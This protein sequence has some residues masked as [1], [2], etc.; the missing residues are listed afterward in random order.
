MITDKFLKKTIDEL[1]TAKVSGCITTRSL[2]GNVLLAKV[3]PEPITPDKL[4]QAI[5]MYLIKNEAQYIGCVT[6][7]DI[8]FA[9]MLPAYRRKGLMSEAMRAIILPH[10]LQQQPMLRLQLQVALFSSQKTYDCAKKLALAVG[11]EMLKEEPGACRMAMDASGLKERVYIKGENEPLSPTDLTVLKNKILYAATILS[12]VQTELEYKQGISGYSEELN[13][14]L[15]MLF[16]HAGKL[17][18]AW[19]EK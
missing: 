14:L 16:A 4:V 7:E 15:K 8:L 3:W 1:N 19:F 9:Y 17:Q 10:L 18:S 2:S 11:F 5:T 12:T 13:D 6:D